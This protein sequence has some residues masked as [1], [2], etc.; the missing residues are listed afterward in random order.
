MS[1]PSQNAPC[2]EARAEPPP[3]LFSLSPIGGEGRGEGVGRT[4][5]H[6]SNSSRGLSYSVAVL[7]HPNPLPLGEGTTSTAFEL[8][9]RPGISHRGLPFSLSQRERAGVRGNAWTTRHLALALVALLV[10]LALPSP[11]QDSVRTLAGLP[12][13]PG[14][15]DEIGRAHV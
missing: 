12:E 9:L 13:T 5:A 15:L 3:A 8:P 14:S 1:Q 10:H 6:R 2:D 7:P 4:S 11:A